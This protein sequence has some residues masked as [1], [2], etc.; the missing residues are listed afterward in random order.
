V[1]A[2]CA[3]ANKGE[4]YFGNDNALCRFKTTDD[5]SAYSDETTVLSLQQALADKLLISG[6]E[7]PEGYHPF[8]GTHYV[9]NGFSARSLDSGLYAFGEPIRAVWSTPNDNA[10]MT[11]VLKT[12]VKRG[13][14]VT[15]APFT[16]SSVTA[17]YKADAGP[18]I[19][20]G[21]Y[22]VDI[23]DM[24]IEVDFSKFSFDTREGP[25]DYAYKKKIKKYKRLKLI[26]ENNEVDAGFGIHEIVIT[27]KLVKKVKK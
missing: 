2:D 12:M 20:I 21:K 7:C 17:Y 24:F 23:S 9:K 1:P 6:N 14:I 22:Y 27:Y 5:M 10:G 15:L 4:L 3:F 18:R 26:F 8:E 13:S 16:H 19:L 25:R 11:E